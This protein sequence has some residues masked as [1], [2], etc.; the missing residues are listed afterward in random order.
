MKTVALSLHMH[1]PWRVR[2]YS[3]FDIGQKSDYFDSPAFQRTQNKYIFEKVAERSYRPMLEML[4]E[5]LE[6]TDFRVSLGVSGVWLEQAMAWRPDLIELLQRAMK[7][8]RVALLGETYYH[9]LAFLYSSLEFDRQVKMHAE[10]M[11][12]LFGAKPRVFCNTG[13]AYNDRLGLWADRK[14]YAGVM[15]EGC[16]NVLGW[17]RGGYVYKPPKAKRVKL[18]MRDYRLS[19]DVSKRFS[20]QSWDGWPLTAEKYVE[21]C[22]A[23]GE[24]DEVVQIGLDM[25][26]FG[27]HNGAETGIFEFFRHFVEQWQAAGNRFLTVEDATKKRATAELTCQETVTGA[28][29]ERDLSGWLENAMQHEIIEKIYALEEAVLLRKDKELASDW[30]RLQC[31][32]NLYFLSTKDFNDDDGVIKMSAYDTPYDAFIYIM[33]ALRDVGYRAGE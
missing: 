7:T 13:L 32:E 4:V 12:K 28:D 9:S 2:H 17:R 10:A 30:R 20:D 8:R 6:T 33:N 5:L 16:E 25:E 21:F 15:A 23:A 22:E 14:G 26:V 3:M 24:A 27:E 1:Q 29:G 18:L 31:V 19:E 11:K